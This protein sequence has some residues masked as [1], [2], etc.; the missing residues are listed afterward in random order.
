MILFNFFAESKCEDRW[1][2]LKFIDV[3]DEEID[4]KVYES[5]IT[6]HSQAMKSEEKKEGDV[7][8]MFGEANLLEA[9]EKGEKVVIKKI[10][11]SSSINVKDIN[12]YGEL[13]SE[14]KLL[15]TA[16]T[17]PR[18]TLI[19][20]D[21][22]SAG[23]KIVEKYWEK[24]GVTETITKE[25][26]EAVKDKKNQNKSEEAKIFQ[27]LITKTDGSEWKKQGLKMFKR[28]YFEQAMKC[29]ER[30]GD[31]E[32]YLKAKANGMA[33]ESTKMLIEVESER[34][35]LKDKRDN[36]VGLSH[37]D[38]VAAKNQLKHN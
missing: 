34:S 17:R 7:E 14:L 6:K 33:N 5:E 38:S 11:A 24:I 3:V 32:L 22:N 4:K 2:I 28:N 23:R 1:P 31:R 8:D 36:A 26:L 25:I 13:C 19:I 27:N 15:Y 29:F 35:Y 10:K 30:C 18:N 12:D 21:E 9:V 20:Y 16:I 37:N